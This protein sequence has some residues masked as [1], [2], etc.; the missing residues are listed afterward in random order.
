M[1][2]LKWLP[3]GKLTVHAVSSL[4]SILVSVSGSTTLVTPYPQWPALKNPLEKYSF[5]TVGA[6]A[7]HFTHLTRCTPHLSLR[8]A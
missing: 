5:T 4:V 1:V 3:N 7:S 6:A 8:S 2:Y